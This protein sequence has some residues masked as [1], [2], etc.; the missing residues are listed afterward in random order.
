M[1]KPD[2]NVVCSRVLFFIRQQECRDILEMRCSYIKKYIFGVD[3]GGTTV[4]MGLFQNNGSLLEKWEIPTRKENNGEA[5]LSDVA[6]SILDKIEE[7][8]ISE[9]VEGIG[10]GVPSAIDKNGVIVGVAANLGWGEIDVPGELGHYL[11]YP[12]KAANDA[13]VAA[14]GE[15]WQGGGKGY[16]NLVFVTLGTGVGGGVII[17]GK[18]VAGIAGGGGELG[19]I[20]LNDEETETC[21]CRNKGCLEQYASATGIVRLA[22]EYLTKEDV[23][24]IL[25]EKEFSAKVFRW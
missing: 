2:Y 1:A 9:E 18:I 11:K 19:H 3:I 14:L 17:D 12:I 20:H 7:K 25:R 22:K 15:M 8:K 4:K 21:G 6:K 10:V 24:S 23:P 16:K 13:N 5:I